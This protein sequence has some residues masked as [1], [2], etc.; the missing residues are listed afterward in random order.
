MHKKIIAT[1][2]ALAAA[3]GA[4][5]ADV[6]YKGII[7]W[8]GASP[9]CAGG[10]NVGDH[11]ETLFHPKGVTGNAAFSSLNRS[12]GYGVEGSTLNGHFNSTLQAVNARGIGES[13]YN[14]ATFTPPGIT[15]VS[16]TS[17][18]VTNLNPPPAT[19][20]LVGQIQNPWSDPELNSCIVSYTFNG[21]KN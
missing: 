18:N 8:N 13:P 15:K 11:Y 2:I 14:P 16:V 4:A 5:Q 19:I 3:S 1:A 12:W 17:P 21:V 20:K 7:V 6:F 10:P 9:A